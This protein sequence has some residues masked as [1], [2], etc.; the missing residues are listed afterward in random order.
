MP[1]QFGLP[2]MAHGMQSPPSPTSVMSVYPRF[3]SGVYRPDHQDQRLTREAMERYLRD[4]SDMVIVILHAK[5][6]QKS[7]GN[8]KRFFCPPPCIY[9]FG[10]GWRMRQE[11]M[12]REGESE[13][14]AQLCAFIG[15]GNS[16]QDMQQL[17][18]N[19]GKQYCAAKTLYISD[20][21]KRK[22][23]MLSVKMFYGSG[24]DIGVFH[25][26][27]IK[28][29]SKPSKKK[30]SLK[31][32]DLCIASGTKVA[33]FNRL[34]S[35]TVS[36]RYLHVENGNFHASSTQWGAFTIHLLDDN[37]S[38][39]EEFQVRDGY[40]HYGSTVKLVCSV[41]GMALPRLVIRKVDKQMASLEADDPVSQLH[42]CAFYMKDT[43]HMYLC[44]SQER[45]IQFQATP[46]P[47]EANKEMI[48]D[49][50]CWTIIST[51]K[52]EYQFFEGMGPVRSPVTPVPLVHSLHLNGGG[53]VAMLEL[54]GDN[55]TPNLQVWFGDVEAETM[56]RCQESM[57]CVVPDISQFR[58]EWL[59]VRQPTQNLVLDLTVRPRMKL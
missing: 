5:V 14:S 15:I 29:I 19:N 3:G 59:W 4:R 8:E 25:S 36:T 51:D 50:A 43:D 2:T 37:E 53:D 31:N 54:T 17:D 28:V 6:A 47:K 55:F 56:Y 10:D 21:D 11:Q 12:L 44:L 9:L 57:L 20:S 18:L 27:R 32:A 23:F 35:Q 26:K 40:V 58:G 42:K 45:I 38:E 33:L 22:H 52:A 48:N 7:Y 34:R 39:S 1:H 16:D 30:Q 46:C 49:G 24:H 41:T 13:Q